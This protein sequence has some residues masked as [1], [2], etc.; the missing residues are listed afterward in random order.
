M[1][2]EIDNSPR[3]YAWGSVHAI[4]QLCGRPASGKPEAELWLGAHPGSPSRIV[5][6]EQAGGARDLAEWISMDS[7]TALGGATT[8]PFLLKVLAAQTALSI[9]AHPSMSQAIAGFARENDAGIPIDAPHRNYRDASHKP[10]LIFCVSETFDALCGI[11]EVSQSSEAIRAFVREGDALKLP[12]DALSRF[13][14]QINENSHD[15]ADVV[16][17]LLESNSHLATEIV[18]QLVAIA[19]AIDPTSDIESDAST[20]RSLSAQ[21][22]DDPGIAVALLMNHV[23][24]RRGQALY[25]EH[26]I[27]HAYLSGLGIEIMAASDN[28]LRGGLTSKHIDVPELLSVGVFRPSPPVI[29]PPETLAPGVDRYAPG[30]PEFELLHVRVSESN[31][32]AEVRIDGPAIALCVGGH[33]RVEGNTSGTDV[34]RGAA[35]FITPDERVIRVTGSG[36]LFI[37]RPGENPTFT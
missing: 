27:M 13:V 11:R 35:I 25:V 3:D 18:A 8:L 32:V 9:Q 4:A 21:Y 5:H 23:Q 22:P 16:A 19:A 6:V 36:E 37:A 2:V 28:V 10:E 14:G 17:L 1:F 34:R 24:L 29:L 7:A 30:V 26:G 33:A 20:V 31:P 12:T 15:V